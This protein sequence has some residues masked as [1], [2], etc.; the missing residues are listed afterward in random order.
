[1]DHKTRWSY[2]SRW[3]C[4]WRLP[5]FLCFHFRRY[6][7]GLRLLCFQQNGVL[8]EEE[9]GESSDSEK[10]RARKRHDDMMDDKSRSSYDIV[11]PY[12]FV[13]HNTFVKFPF[14]ALLPVTTLLLLP[15]RRRCG[16]SQETQDL[17]GTGGS[18]SDGWWL[19]CTL[20]GE[21]SSS[22]TNSSTYRIVP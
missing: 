9:E 19:G 4:Y 6:I 22:L 3:W 18:E 12:S 15:G 5:T 14:S 2:G 1:M 8:L 16:G 11:T 13:V 17:Q 21:S 20:T 10:Y 7:G